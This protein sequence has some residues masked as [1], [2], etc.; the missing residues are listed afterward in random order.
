M[1]VRLQLFTVPGQVYYGAT[2]KLVLSGA[3]GVVFVADSQAGAHGREP[4]VARGPE[5]EPRG[6]QPALSQM[7]H[8]F[9]WNKRDLR[10]WCRSRSSSGRFNVHGAPALGTC[11]D[12]R[13]RRLRG[14]RA[15]HAPRAARSTRRSCRRASRRCSGS[16]CGGRRGLIAEAI[17][18]LAEAPLVTKDRPSMGWRRSVRRMR[19][20]R[21]SPK[22]GSAPRRPLSRLRLRARARPRIAIPARAAVPPP[23]VASPAA[24]AFSPAAAAPARAATSA[25][26]PPGHPQGAPARAPEN[27]VTVG[28]LPPALAVPTIA[29]PPG[30]RTF[31]WRSYGRMGAGERAPDRDAPRRPRRARRRPRV[32]SAPHESARVGRVALGLGGRTS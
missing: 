9:H 8:T 23:L 15:D 24:V 28:A 31:R 29:P 25:A 12:A 17:R 2:R 18:G 30:R 5:R 27:S 10:T 16:V 11:R 6:A 26:P 19:S 22:R 20:H 1:S 4:G 3:D 21:P 32:R 13:R 14:A 7:P